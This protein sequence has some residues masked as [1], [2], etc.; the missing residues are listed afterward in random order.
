[1]QYMHKYVYM[2]IY[3]L[4]LYTNQ[5]S[6]NKAEIP[7]SF[8]PQRKKIVK[9]LSFLRSSQDDVYCIYILYNYYIM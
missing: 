7:L 1:M 8:L 9:I 4:D 5:T 3:S 6:N 2:D